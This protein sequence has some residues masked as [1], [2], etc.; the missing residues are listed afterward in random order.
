VLQ[1][2]HFVSVPTSEF[3]IRYMYPIFDILQRNW[4]LRLFVII[5]RSTQT[6][7]IAFVVKTPVSNFTDWE[8][9][10]ILKHKFILAKQDTDWNGKS[11]CSIDRIQRFTLTFK[12]FI[13]M[14]Y[15]VPLFQPLSLS[16]NGLQCFFFIN[17]VPLFSPSGVRSISDPMI[18]VTFPTLVVYSSRHSLLFLTSVTNMLFI[19]L[20]FT[21]ISWTL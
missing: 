16:R 21:D 13:L 20:S 7:P 1:T 14:L 11:N 17:L 8:F 9:G 10:N 2:V 5:L 4:M 3:Q 6:A 15:F 12:S 19:V 18:C